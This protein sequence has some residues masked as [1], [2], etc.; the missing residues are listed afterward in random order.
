MWY[1]LGSNFLSDDLRQDTLLENVMQM[2][3]TELSTSGE[4]PEYDDDA[5]DDDDAS[6]DVRTQDVGAGIL[7]V[8]EHEDTYSVCTH[9]AVLCYQKALNVLDRSPQT[10]GLCDQNMPPN[11]AELYASIYCR[12]ADCYV[13]TSQLDRAVV[14]YERS[15]PYFHLA[16]S[17]GTLERRRLL[18]ALNAHALSMLATVNFLL[19]SF[20]RASIIY[21]TAMMLHHQLHVD[22]ATTT[23]ESAW[24]MTMYGLTFAA[25]GRDHQCVIWCL[26][27]FAGYVAVLRGKILEVEPLRRWFVVETLYTLARAY[28]TLEDG[29]TKAVH[30]LT[31]AKNLANAAPDQQMDF[32]QTIEVSQSYTRTSLSYSDS[33]G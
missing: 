28:T 31:V 13:L 23:L 15:L 32:P 29:A 16:A 10:G 21:E 6:F 5:D 25:L 27:A 19:H 1:Q 24:N 30:Y 9:E 12:L 8:E 26:R 2:V 17:G 14:T 11:L 20:W 7:D 18:L 4:K 33:S 22:D 3:K